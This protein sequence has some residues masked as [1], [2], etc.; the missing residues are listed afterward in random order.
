MAVS[1]VAA[2]RAVLVAAA[3]GVGVASQVPNPMPSRF[4][5]VTRAGGGRSRQL[6]QP[7]ILVECFAST[8]AGAPDGPAAEQ[9]ALTA[10]DALGNAASAGPWASGWITGWDGNTIADYPD[11]DQSRHARW[12]F[13]GSLYLLT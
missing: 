12:Q 11:P 9:M 5:R 3:P 2:A 10:Y 13:S 1:A 7:R 6:D 4:I 8:V